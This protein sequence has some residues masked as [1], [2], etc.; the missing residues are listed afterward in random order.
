L[1]SS[2]CNSSPLGGSAAERLQT[3]ACDTT[4]LI[5]Q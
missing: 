1:E 5:M 4:L 3:A 2:S